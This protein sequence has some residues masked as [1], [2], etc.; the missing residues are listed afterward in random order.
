MG[1][2]SM[3]VGLRAASSV[4]TGLAVAAVLVLH[5]GGRQSA[6][7]RPGPEQPPDLAALQERAREAVRKASPA[8]VAVNGASG[9]IVSAEGLILS[10]HHVTHARGEKPGQKVTVVLPDGT[11]A[12]AELLGADPVYDLSALRLTKP[13]PHPHAPLAA[14]APGLGDAVL[15]LGYLRDSKRGRP[16][17]VRLGRVLCRSG[18]TLVTDCPTTGGDSGGPYVDLDGR[19]VG[20]IRSSVVPNAI[21]DQGGGLRVRGVQPYSVTPSTFIRTRLAALSRGETAGAAEWDKLRAEVVG[22]KAPVLEADRW[23]QGR[24]SRAAFSAAAAA[25]RDGVAEVLDGDLPVALGTVVDAA[26]LIVTAASEVPD[27]ARCRLPGGR[28][29]EAAVVG[30]NP[31]YNLALLRVEARGLKPVAW[32]GETAAPAGTLLAAPGPGGV[33][34]AVGVVSVPRRDVPG[35]HPGTID[36]R[37]PPAGPPELIGSA[38]QGRGYWVEYAEGNAAAAGVRPGDLVLSVGAAPVRSHQDLL[39]CVAG[40]PAGAR[41]P[42]RVL[43]D[44]RAVE[45]TLA[46]RPE[47]LQSW[48]SART[49]APPTAFDHDLPLTAAECGGPVVALDGKAVGVTVARVGQHGCVAVPADR[50]AALLADLKAG[51]PLPALPPAPAPPKGGPAGKPVKATVED[52]KARLRERGDRFR[53][54]L[55]EYE[56][57]TEAH[58]DPRQLVAWQL[59]PV[60][61]VTSRCLVAFAGP[62]RLT[63]ISYPR[64]RVFPYPADRVAPDPAAPAA[65]AARHREAGRAAAASRGSGSLDHLLAWIPRPFRNRCLYD[66]EALYFN[67]ITQDAK[68][69]GTPEYFYGPTDYLSNLGLRPVDPQP[70]A[71]GRAAQEAHRFPGN[72]ARYEAARVR[73]AEELVDGAACVVVEGE[74]ADRV[75]GK[76]VRVVEALW[77]DP[78]LGYAPRKWEA[79][80]A[81][82][83]L[84]RRA[85]ADFREFAPGCW[86]PLESAWSVGAPLW[87]T[88][89]LRDGPALSHNMRLRWAR[90]NDVPGSV[91]D[92]D[93]V[94]R[95]DPDRLFKQ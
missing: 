44:G 62:K 94:F 40:H 93:R 16:A 7:A 45:L 61:D 64:L 2:N 49:V 57:T 26:G 55:V 67:V 86:L 41:V 36:R 17:V 6:V 43:R 34:L 80:A 13:G 29:A 46:L 30:V 10:Q 22:L 76:R 65:V 42:V 95:Y 77:L 75:D 18:D 5:C 72:F 82:R 78:A 1:S 81:G 35:P 71:K 53:S 11:K 52:V 60:R 9:V 85:N 84:W 24:A 20:I 70:G 50:V 4:S 31:A 91:F 25:T 58:A 59:E 33:A 21:T 56:V 37:R 83:L 66:G 14:A 15:K 3:S 28:V 68:V 69:R 8:V 54:L 27:G 47:Q 19:V 23:A 32:A 92:P 63:D 38:V 88:T 12:E 74:Y 87:A 79:R 90:V 48:A 51:R 89:D 39:G 73:P